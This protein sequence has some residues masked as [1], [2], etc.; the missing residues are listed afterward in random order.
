MAKNF[1]PGY[2]IHCL[3]YHEYL[4][5]DHVFPKSWYPKIAKENM[6]KW[7]I[8]SCE[9][10]NSMYGK[11]ENNL[12]LRFGLCVDPNELKSLGISTRALRSINPK[13]GRNE[14]DRDMR[15]K[16]L[17]KIQRETFPASQ[18]RND[19]YFPN[20]GPTN[21]LNLEDQ[22]GIMIS[23]TELR[24]MAE[25]LIRGITYII[26]KSFIKS[27]HI[28]NIFFLDDPDAKEIEAIITKFGADHYNGPGI[29]IGRA[30]VDKDPLS[31]VFKIEIWG[32][33]KMYG[34]VEPNRND[35]I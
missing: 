17:E 2:C 33:F 35:T 27:D 9:V 7:Q 34:I 32:R 22:I 14:K 5:S 25:K 6:E 16:R 30:V 21:N 4:T 11:L 31:G 18:F 12:L 28:I 26:S 8:P 10:C 15:K 23:D 1:P 29:K 19:S 20:F 24:K 13:F 3:N